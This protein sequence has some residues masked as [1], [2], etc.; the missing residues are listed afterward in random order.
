[1]IH[2]TFT[3]D[4]YIYSSLNLVEC[5]KG[6]LTLDSVCLANKGGALPSNPASVRG[7][8]LMPLM[9]AAVRAAVTHL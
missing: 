3:T 5:S 1:M 9:G 7:S 8:T 4:L 2:F 6:E